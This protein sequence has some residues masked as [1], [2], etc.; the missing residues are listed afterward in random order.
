VLAKTNF[1]KST[2]E[3]VSA[4]EQT[5]PFRLR[6][7]DFD[8]ICQHDVDLWLSVAK[9]DCAGNAD[10]FALDRGKSLIGRYWGP[11]RNESSECL[12][13]VVSSEIDKCC[14]QWAGCYGND[15][16]AHLDFFADI[17]SGF[18]IFYHFWLVRMGHNRAEKQS[19]DRK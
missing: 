18:R 3:K 5:S 14:T 15:P 7:Q 1:L 19:E 9:V 11:G 16:A 10:D 4:K 17:P 2:K 12:I 6:I 13:G 8:L